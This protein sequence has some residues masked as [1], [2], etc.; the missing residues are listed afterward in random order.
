[1][2]RKGGGGNTRA[3][4]KTFYVYFYLQLFSTFSNDDIVYILYDK[5]EYD[6][7]N[8]TC[9]SCKRFFVHPTPE[10]NGGGGRDTRLWVREG[11]NSEDWRKSLAHY[12]L[13]A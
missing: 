12:L 1:M 13:C 4:R 10:P 8:V 11:P 5:Y 3:L 7:S 9:L 6:Q 2:L